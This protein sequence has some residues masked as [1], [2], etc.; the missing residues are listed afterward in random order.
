MQQKS[1]STGH[2]LASIFLGAIVFSYVLLDRPLATFVFQSFH[3][4][5]K[6][7]AVPTH[8]VDWLEVAAVLILIWSAWVFSRGDGLGHKGM[9]ALRATLA[10]LLGIGVKEVA[11][12]AFGRT[13]PETWVCDNPSFIKGGAFGF[14]PFHGGA[15]WSSFP[16]GHQTLVCAVAGCLWILAPRL[17][18]L[19]AVTVLAVALGLLGADYH[20]LS[21][22][23]AGGLIGWLVGV[24]AAKLELPRIASI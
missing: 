13:W 10:L 1:A 14:T 3:S 24:F 23:F 2:I 15:G 17:R 9:V 19:Y 8:V 21:D 22:I 5:R 4:S 7:F 18:P 12:L 11:K 16:S 6:L 20:W